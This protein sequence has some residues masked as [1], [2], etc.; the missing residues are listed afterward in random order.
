MGTR[1]NA[2]LDQGNKERERGGYSIGVCPF[3]SFFLKT[4]IRAASL[5]LSSL[6]P[7]LVKEKDLYRIFFS[8]F[9][10]FLHFFDS[11]FK[12]RTFSCIP[13]LEISCTI[14]Y[15]PSKNRRTTFLPSALRMLNFSPLLSHL[16]SFPFPACFL[17]SSPRA[18]WA[19]S[20]WLEEAWGWG[21]GWAGLGWS[22]RMGVGGWEEEGCL[23]LLVQVVWE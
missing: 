9:L 3:F 2:T 19:L 7:S 14:I 20:S 15:L 13:L 1:I 16:P 21:W 6:L 23:A 22:G 17:P 11:L 18:G 8:F 4:N 12:P 10:L 5:F